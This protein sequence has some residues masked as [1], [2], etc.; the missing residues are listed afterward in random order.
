MEFGL[1]AIP[2]GGSPTGAGESPALPSDFQ[3]RIAS[4]IPLAVL[5]VGA[6]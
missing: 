6:T 1:F 5:K 4:K 2:F 3:R